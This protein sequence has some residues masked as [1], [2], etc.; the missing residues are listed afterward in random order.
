MITLEEAISPV[1]TIGTASTPAP[2]AGIKKLNLGGIATKKESGKTEYPILPD[3]ATGNVASLVGAIRS[4]AAQLEALEGSLEIDKG[5]LTSLAK[6]F[7]FVHCHG[8]SVIPSS[9]ACMD[10]TN[11]I[12]ISFQNRYKAVTDEAAITALIG[13]DASTMF[14]QKFLLKI[15]GDLIPESKAE[16]ILEELQAIFAKHECSGALTATASIAPIKEFHT[17]R[18][19]AYTPEVNLALD[20]VSPFIAA[21]KTKGRVSK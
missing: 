12:L 3:D 1:T 21:V 4:K 9:V 14:R 10:G 19:T 20:R 16:A 5:E 18:H 15:D 17:R 13:D 11:E 2:K 6:Q 8:K 7:F